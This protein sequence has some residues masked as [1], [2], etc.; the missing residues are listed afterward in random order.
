MLSLDEAIKHCE[1]V[2]EAEERNAKLHQRPDRGIKGSGKRYLS[3]LEC[4]SEHR[5]LAE[6]LKKLQAYEE[7]KEEIIRRKYSDQWS[8]TVVIHIIDKH[9][10]EVNADE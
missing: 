1:E 5:Q 4:A 2:A 9:L 3:C 6:W 10:K 7:A 8:K